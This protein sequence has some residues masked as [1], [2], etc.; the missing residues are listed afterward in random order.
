MQRITITIDVPDRVDPAAFVAALAAQYGAVQLGTRE[1]V[2][3]V[4]VFVMPEAVNF[5]GVRPVD[6]PAPLN[7]GSRDWP[8][9]PPETP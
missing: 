7:R 6:P 2:C 8:D 9:A 4:P 3:E 5:V 1:E